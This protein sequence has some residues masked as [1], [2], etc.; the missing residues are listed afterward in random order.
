M[1][2]AGPTCS[3]GKRATWRPGS[4]TACTIGYEAL[5]NSALAI[6]SREEFIASLTTNMPGAPDH[7]GRCSAINGAGPAVVADLPPVLPLAPKVFR[8][9]A[10]AADAIVLDIRSYEAFGG[11]HVPGAYHISLAGNFATFAGW[12]LPPDKD[13]LIVSDDP[14]SIDECATWLR[15]VG[16][17]RVAGSLAGGMTAWSSAGYELSHLPQVG[18]PELN[19]MVCSG[20]G[21]VL[22]DTRAPNEF[23]GGH[24]D[25]AINIPAPDLRTRYVELDP[26]RPTVLTCN[27]GNRSS[28]GAALLMQRG[29][30]K[31]L[32][33]AG[34]MTA[35]AAAGLG[36][37]CAR[38]VAP[39]GPRFTAT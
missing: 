12:V 39:H 30:T 13:I 9:R 31:L 5:F 1:T 22:V 28:L 14:A 27:S 32:N 36:P 16:L 33:A 7:F 38:C 6:A 19:A 3:P 4:T 35:W 34:G 24:I 25:G 18:L 11:A 15:R 17:D 20:T 26:E 21:I 37:E 29:F 10:A 8:E 2:W 23:A